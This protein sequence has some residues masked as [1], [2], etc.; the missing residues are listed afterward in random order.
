MK[1]LKLLLTLGL[2]TLIPLGAYAAPT[3]PGEEG[4]A[5]AGQVGV[6][7]DAL[8]Q[9][10][11]QMRNGSDPRNGAEFSNPD[12]LVKAEAFNRQAESAMVEFEAEV[13]PILKEAN[14][15]AS[16]LDKILKSK[17]YTP[18]QKQALYS[19]QHESAKIAFEGLTARYREAL[20]RLYLAGFSDT[21]LELVADSCT[22]E[23]ILTGEYSGRYSAF[24]QLRVRSE[25][26]VLNGRTLKPRVYYYSYSDPVGKF[27]DVCQKQLISGSAVMRD[28]LNIAELDKLTST[29]FPE[30]G[31]V[32]LLRD[33]LR[34][35]FT[36][37]LI[38]KGCYTSSCVFLY[39]AHRKSFVELVEATLDKGI[40]IHSAPGRYA[41]LQLSGGALNTHQPRYLVSVR[42][43]E[44]SHL[45]FEI[46]EEEYREKEAERQRA[47]A[48]RRQALLQE[49]DS[50]LTAGSR[51][52]FSTWQCSDRVA[53]IKAS[54][55]QAAGACLS[56]SERDALLRSIDGAKVK[57]KPERVACVQTP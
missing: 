33:E 37:E 41:D 23:Q 2:T 40:P 47:E 50:L 20:R 8:E 16:R 49:L 51:S 32:S 39:S 13:K 3:T 56:D 22:E 48:E 38:V 12:F 17:N 34:K 7:R 11:T 28:G 57:S 30:S 4:E 44:A 5:L 31:L 43:E 52:W 54:L 26:A 21:R 46:S 1:S 29:L 24:V 55:C 6:T 9:I 27:F 14:F 35:L 25:V 42:T 18:E 53:E 15:Y 36:D 19:S 45:P 10:L